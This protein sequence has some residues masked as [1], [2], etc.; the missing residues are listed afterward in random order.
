MRGISH[1]GGGDG[2]KRMAANRASG[3]QDGATETW[4]GLNDYFGDGERR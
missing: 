4:G 3:R 2:A 1:I